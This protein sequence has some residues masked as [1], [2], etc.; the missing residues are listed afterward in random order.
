MYD[1]VFNAVDHQRI[2]DLPAWRRWLIGLRALLE[3]GKDPDRTDKVLEAYE[4][5]NAGGEPRRARA[6]YASPDGE[7]LFQANA[8]LDATTVDFD[9]LAQLPEG[10]LGHAYATFMKQRGLT[11]DLFAARGELSR[12][13]YVIKRL[14]QT[15]DLWHV[16]TG[17]DTDV[18][19]ELELQAFTFTQLWI[20]SAF[21]LVTLGALRWLYRWPGLPV[22]V[23]RGMRNGLR[24]RLLSPVRW[25]QHWA[26]P[27]PQL[28]RALLARG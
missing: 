6:F 13:V 8:S 18:P 15:H 20:P 12:E 10:T 1:L 9:A 16:L 3:V 22:R 7:A 4:H 5:L 25:E 28:R 24:A 26:T 11:P 17:I 19:G 23:L 2:N 27:L 21:L 14:R